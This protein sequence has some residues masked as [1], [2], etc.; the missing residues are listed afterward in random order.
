MYNSS[1]YEASEAVSISVPQISNV[2]SILEALSLIQN[3]YV[4]QTSS[5]LSSKQ[6]EQLMQSALSLAIQ[7]ATLQAQVAAGSNAV[8]IRNMTVS[9]GYVYP[10]YPAAYSAGVNSGPE[11]NPLFFSGR[12]GVLEQV[13]V[14]FVYK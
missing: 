4:T 6:S 14:E 3:V 5:S 7:N 13:T 11:Q 10:A 9:K 2:S 8:S 12:E 1:K